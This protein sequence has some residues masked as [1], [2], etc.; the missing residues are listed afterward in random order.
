[1]FPIG[2]HVVGGDQRVQEFTRTAEVGGQPIGRQAAL[3]AIVPLVV[4]FAGDVVP[5]ATAALRRMDRL[6]TPTEIIRDQTTQRARRLRALPARPLAGSPTYRLDD[7]PKGL[8][9]DCLV[10][11]GMSQ[12]PLWGISSR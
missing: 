5:I 3:L 2:R 11:A 6:V 10:L 4:F 7:L 8:I 9:D 1:M 12:P